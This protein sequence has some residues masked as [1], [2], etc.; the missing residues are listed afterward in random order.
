MGYVRVKKVL[1]L[2]GFRVNLV[3]GGLESLELDDTLKRIV[4]SA[5]FPTLLLYVW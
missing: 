5:S 4:L 3:V 1:L 2:M